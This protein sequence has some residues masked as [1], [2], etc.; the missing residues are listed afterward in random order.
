W[1]IFLY[2]LDDSGYQLLSETV[3]PHICAGICFYAPDHIFANRFTVDEETYTYFYRIEQDYSL[4]FLREIVSSGTTSL[5]ME[6]A[7]I[8]S[9]DGGS[10]IDTT[11]PDNPA[12]SH[13]ISLPTNA[14][15]VATFDGYEHYLFNDTFHS[16]LLGSTFGLRGYIYG[17]NLRF[18]Q[19]GCFFNPGPVSCVKARIDAISD[20]EDPFVPELPQ[21]VKSYP[22]PFRSSATIEFS[23]SRNEA[24][25]LE[26]FN[27]RGQKVSDLSRQM[28]GSGTHQLEWD[29]IDAKGN[30]LGS[31]IYFL[32]IRT[33]G[34]SYLHKLVLLN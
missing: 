13:I 25:T 3:V 15:H 12:V 11:D 8:Q 28:Y 32:R 22:N 29:G 30:K 24:V 19:Q 5:I 17:I 2:T 4:T 20:N 14:G 26:V 7:I 9:I 27:Y 23:L 31:G 6:N 18:Y 21:T 34:A 16:F 1:R 33:S 10:V